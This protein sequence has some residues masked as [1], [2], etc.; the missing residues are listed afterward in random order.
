MIGELSALHTFVY[1]GEYP[2][3][4][5]GDAATAAINQVASLGA[6]LQRS[7]EKRGYLVVDIPERDPGKKL[8][9]AA[10]LRIVIHHL[11]Y[12]KFVLNPDFHMIDGKK[13]CCVAT[14]LA[15]CYPS[16]GLRTGFATKFS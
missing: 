4:Y 9:C 8:C 6:L 13:R 2:S 10:T 16:L 7:V 5:H 11:A 15:K 1:G 12:A 3:P 14:W